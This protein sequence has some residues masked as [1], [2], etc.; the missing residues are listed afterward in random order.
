MPVTEVESQRMEAAFLESTGFDKPLETTDEQCLGV[1]VDR[2]GSMRSM[3]DELVS[4][5]NVFMTEQRKLGSCRVSV[6]QFDSEIETVLNDVP[7]ESVQAFGDEHFIPRGATAL[8]D[9][10]GA[11]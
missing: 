4:G 7:I 8:L 1:V 5:L 9:A 11:M 6:I 2:S 3:R 10:I